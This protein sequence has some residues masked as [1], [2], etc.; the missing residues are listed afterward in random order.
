MVVYSS[1]RNGSL[2]QIKYS[3]PQLPQ[4]KAKRTAR[5]AARCCAAMPVRCLR[6][7][8]VA[9]AG[10]AFTTPVLCFLLQIPF[11]LPRDHQLLPGTNEQKKLYSTCV[12]YNIVGACSLFSI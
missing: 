7:V 2:G 10:R 8:V 5:W 4:F 1:R 12:L 3:D 6:L 9:R 11:I